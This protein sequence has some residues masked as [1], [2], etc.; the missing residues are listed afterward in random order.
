[1]IHQRKSACLV[2]YVLANLSSCISYA[3][4]A[5]VLE[6]VTLMAGALH[7]L[8][9][10]LLSADKWLPSE[11]KNNRLTRLPGNSTLK[12][13][14]LMACAGLSLVLIAMLAHRFTHP[15]P[16]DA[17]MAVFAIPGLLAMLTTA[18]FAGLSLA[19]T[20]QAV[21]GLL[22]TLTVPA[23]AFGAGITFRYLALQDLDAIASAAIVVIIGIRAASACKLWF[24]G[25]A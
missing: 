7:N 14:L 21:S 6:S 8:L 24:E 1:M 23:I 9:A 19:R 3:V 25:E 18:T 17:L 15:R 13:L 4:G 11:E 12:L 22:A 16:V 2:A 10:L 20:E 5:V